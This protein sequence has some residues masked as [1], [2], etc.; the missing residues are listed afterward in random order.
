[1]HSIAKL[2][3]AR[4]SS[5]CFL[6]GSWLVTQRSSS[7]TEIIDAKG[8]TMRLVPAGIFNMGSDAD[9]D[10]RNAEHR[11][12]LDAFHIDIY[13]VTNARYEECVIAGV[14]EPPHFAKSDFRE[15]Y[16]GNTEFVNYPV[17]Y[18]DW[19]MARTYCESWR[20]ARLPTEAECEKAARGTD[21]RSYS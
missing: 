18:V 9:G 17:I 12:H 7:A 10:N 20:E 14:C 1:L 21:E 8:V 15:S 4:D 6:F 3:V 13:E 19:M 16:Y 2:L 11:V 5:Y